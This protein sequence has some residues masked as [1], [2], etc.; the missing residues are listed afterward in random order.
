MG[1]AVELNFDPET[2]ERI[3]QLTAQIYATC[4][5]FDLLGTGFVPHISLA[6]Y[7]QV[8]EARLP[9]V[10][11]AFARRTAPMPIQLTAIGLFPTT[12]GV[13]YL[14]PV[15]TGELLGLHRTYSAAAA[16]SGYIAHPYYQP[17]HWIP[18][19]TVAQGLAGEQIH[20]AVQLCL[21]SHVFQAGQLLT[22]DL[23]EYPPA[24]PI[25]R[26]PLGG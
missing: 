15:V 12:Q 8:D 16:A 26:F 4:G 11:E 18:H 14:A 6:G 3:T 13:V 19:C 9:G 1:Y 17:G 2:T 7:E 24:R 10:V 21:Q 22:I 23:I 25:C 20:T 5:G